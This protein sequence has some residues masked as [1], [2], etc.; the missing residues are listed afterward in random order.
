MTKVAAPSRAR[1][2]R[3]TS[4]ER[5]ALYV[6]GLVHAREAP[7][8]SEAPAGIPGASPPRTLGGGRS[9]WLVVADAPLALYGEPAIE[10]GLKSLTWVSKIALAHEAMIEHVMQFGTVIPM[11][12]LT[13]FASEE[14]ALAHVQSMRRRL[15]RLIERVAGRFEYGVR[16]WFQPVATPSGRPAS[17]RKLGARFLLAKKERRDAERE[18]RFV[19][20]ARAQEIFEQLASLADD[21]SRRAPPVGPGT[22][23][24]ILDATFLV[25]AAAQKKFRTSLE[26]WRRQ[27]APRGFEVSLTGPWPPYHF[28]EMR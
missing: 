23:R 11:K 15:E 25:R 6:Y 8:L 1:D 19:A 5:A 10:K 26:R 27:L 14:R 21:A 9:L 18:A 13:L 28:V 22:A 3:P 7:D 17:T 2:H 16:L 20:H 4:R 12:M 24:L